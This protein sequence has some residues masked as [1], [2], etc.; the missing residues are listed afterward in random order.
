MISVVQ[1]DDGCTSGSRDVLPAAGD[2]P[3]GLPVAENEHVCEVVG[4]REATGQSSISVHPSGA[5]TA[6]PWMVAVRSP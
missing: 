2:G 1:E 4:S 5:V 6:M 3:I